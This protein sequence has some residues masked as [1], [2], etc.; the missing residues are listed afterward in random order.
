MLVLDRKPGQR[1][2]IYVPLPSGGEVE[3]CVSLIAVRADAE[4]A[5]IG[6]EGPSNVLFL[7]GEIERE[8][9]D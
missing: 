1:V 4:R 3:L 6:F 2:R 7:R 8:G 5:K 9:N